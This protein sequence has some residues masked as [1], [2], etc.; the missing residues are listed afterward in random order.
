[1]ATINGA[2]GP[3]LLQLKLCGVAAVVV[4]SPYWLYQIWA[5]IV[6]G[7]HP[8][9]RKWTRVFVAVAGPAVLRRRRGRLLRAAQGPGGADRL[10]PGRR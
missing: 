3:L 10:H 8:H 1:M 2:G 9:E 5:F 6:P 4:T 7:L